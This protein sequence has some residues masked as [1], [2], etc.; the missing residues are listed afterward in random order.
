M[1]KSKIPAS[2]YLKYL[3]A[4][5]SQDEFWGR[6]LHIF[7]DIWTPIDERIGQMDLYLDPNYTPESFLPWLA[8]W[9]GINLNPRMSLREQRKLIQDLIE[10]SSWRGTRRGLREH[11][12]LVTG[13]EPQIS[14]SGSGMVLDE[15][16]QL[17]ENTILSSSSGRN[18]LLI[19]IFVD[20]PKKV[21]RNL[22]EGIIRTH[23]PA[24]AT[25]SLEI[26][27]N[28]SQ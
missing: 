4:I 26:I 15:A 12:K 2:S 28:S 6:F 8:S 17:G 9:M 14:E 13:L 3:P 23:C 16:S 10:L 1:E 22:V 11:I 21:N 5:Y 24:Q 27:P 7:E 19:T 25:Y 20:D 18:H